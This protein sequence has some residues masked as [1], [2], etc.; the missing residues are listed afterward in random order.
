MDSIVCVC[1]K[2]EQNTFLQKGKPSTWNFYA[3][4]RVG[5]IGDPSDF[6]VQIEATVLFLEMKG[7]ALLLF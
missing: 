5:A 6:G 2:L 7:T 3:G 4:R 1:P